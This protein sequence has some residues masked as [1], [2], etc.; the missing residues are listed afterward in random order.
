MLNGVPRLHPPPT[1]P[2]INPFVIGIH[3]VSKNSMRMH[4]LYHFGFD[5]METVMNSHAPFIYPIVYY[6]NE[7][8]V[9]IFVLY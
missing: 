2:F 1:N 8:H 4:L 5:L 6:G 7:M 3:C 9:T